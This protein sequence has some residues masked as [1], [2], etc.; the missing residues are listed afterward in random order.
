MLSAL[1]NIFVWPPNLIKF[2]YSKWIV[3]NQGK[4]CF[5]LQFQEVEKQGVLNRKKMIEGGGKKVK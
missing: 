4:I 1:E 2:N 3:M 5:F